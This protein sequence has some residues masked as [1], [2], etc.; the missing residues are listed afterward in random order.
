M[1][2]ILSL[3]AALAAAG[4][5]PQI[6]PAADSARAAAAAPVAPLVA[7]PVSKLVLPKGT[8]VRLMVLKEVN[9]RDNRP[10]DRFVL[11]VDEDV[12]THGVTVVPTGAKAWGEL[13]AADGTGGAGKSGRLN[14]RLLYVEAGT[15]HIDLDGTRQ[16]SGSGGTAQVVASVLAFG[17]LGLLAKGNNAS[18]KAGEILNGY[19]LSDAS[20]DA[21]IAERR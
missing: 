4:A 2:L 17:P 11:R 10:G 14:A 3:A 7:T 1:A 9:S 18:L 16:S 6:D 13:V 19:T 8:L 12:R 15:Q 20:F 5:Q 21:S